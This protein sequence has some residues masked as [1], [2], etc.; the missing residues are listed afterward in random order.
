MKLGAYTGQQ[1]KNSFCGVVTE[2]RANEIVALYLITILLFQQ[3]MSV[4]A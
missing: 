3:Y 4:S 2:M 1:Q